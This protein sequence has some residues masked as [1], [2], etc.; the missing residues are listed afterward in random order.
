MRLLR[1]GDEEQARGITVEA[2][3]D[4]RTRG[5][6]TGRAQRDEALN[7][8]SR[9]VSAC[10]MRDEPRR[11]VDDHEVVVRVHDVDREATPR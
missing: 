1:A 6:A 10:G 3:H 11:L 5:I 8:R 7:E 9:D 4:A 2:M